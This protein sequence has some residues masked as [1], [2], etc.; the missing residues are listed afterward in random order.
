[1]L[2]PESNRR[3]FNIDYHIGMAVCGWK[4]D[5]RQVV[6]RARQESNQY[7]NFYGSEVPGSLLCDR[8]SSYVHLYTLYSGY[9]PFGACTLLSSYQNK[10]PELFM[11]DPSGTSYGYHAVA[12]GKGKQL[13]KTELE[14]LNPSEMTCLDAAKEITRII[15][16]VH[17]KVKD[18]EF[19]LEL[20]WVGEVSKGVHE[21][22]PKKIYDDLLKEMKEK[23]KDS[24][25]E[26]IQTDD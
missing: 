21:M 16:L 11:I 8:V 14:K 12:V 2:E 18:K 9:R 26:E 19:M 1:M 24:D 15:H 13:A 6:N 22:V 3:I 25:D 4:P 7:R 5:C 23:E 17:D 20:S 10:K